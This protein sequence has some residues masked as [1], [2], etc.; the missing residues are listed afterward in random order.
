[1]AEWAPHPFGN[2]AISFSAYTNGD[3]IINSNASANTKGS[4]ELIVSSTQ[5]AYDMLSVTFSPN[6]L[7]TRDF[8]CDIAIGAAA[9][10]TIIINNLA[11]SASTNWVPQQYLFPIHVPAGT[12]ISARTQCSTGSSNHEL[13]FHGYATAFDGYAGCTSVE[14]WGA[15]TGDSGGTSIDPG[16][17]A[18]VVG[19]YSPLVTSTTFD[20]KW[21]MVAFGNQAQA[22]RATTVGDLDISVGAGGSEQIIVPGIRFMTNGT[23][24]EVL[25]HTF[26]PVPVDIPAGSRVAARCVNYSTNASPARLI[27]LIVYGIG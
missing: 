26:G 15:V 16:G 22:S 27:D 10:E 21:L 18:G 12:R 2:R 24:D 19:A 13:F 6:T 9:S 17:T 4:Y 23:P 11:Y 14:T 3:G 1:M 20:V 25:P 8:L 7:A 5:H